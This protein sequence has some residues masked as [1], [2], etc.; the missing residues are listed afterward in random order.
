MGKRI[1]FRQEAPTKTRNKTARN[2]AGIVLPLYH[3]IQSIYSLK[4]ITLMDQNYIPVRGY[5]FDDFIGTSYFE[6]SLK[7]RN[8]QMSPVFCGANDKHDDD[9]IGIRLSGYA[10]T[11][12]GMKQTSRILYPAKNFTSEDLARL[13]DKVEG[14]GGVVRYAPKANLTFDEVFVRVCYKAPG[15][16][17]PDEDNLKWVV[18]IDGGEQVALHGDRRKYVAKDAE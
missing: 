12:A 6:K 16:P 2:G 5:D 13:F 11:E 17:N 14:E 18:A 3:T 1:S 7:M 4:Q 10:N 9:F 8:P 15:K